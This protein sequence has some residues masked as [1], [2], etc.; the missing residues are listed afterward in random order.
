VRGACP[1]AAAGALAWSDPAAWAGGTAP[2]PGA[3]AV[4]PAGKT[5]VLSAAGLTT[6]GSVRVAG[7]LVLAPQAGC[8][9]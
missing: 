6:V 3:A 9:E 7:T 2:A 1:E 8:V 4:V 5:V